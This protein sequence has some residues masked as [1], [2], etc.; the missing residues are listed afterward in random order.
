MKHKLI[1]RK[2]EMHL[3]VTNVNVH[4]PLCGWTFTADATVLVTEK[5]IKLP[6]HQKYLSHASC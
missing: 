4:L 5:E 2:A 3:C 1:W 6:C